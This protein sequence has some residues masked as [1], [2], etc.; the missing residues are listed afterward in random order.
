MTEGTTVYLTRMHHNT[1]YRPVSK[2]ALAQCFF[3]DAKREVKLSIQF[4]V[5]RNLMQHELAA[6]QQ[7]QLQAPH[8]FSTPCCRCACSKAPPRHSPH[9]LSASH[10][11]LTNTG[12]SK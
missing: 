4:L 8:T 6:G 10:R 7:Q 12:L 9:T 1:C 11:T 5:V 2:H 3:Q